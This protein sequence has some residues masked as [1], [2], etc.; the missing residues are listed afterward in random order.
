MMLLAFLL[1]FGGSLAL[2]LAMKRHSTQLMPARAYSPRLALSLRLL[3]SAM[4]I[5]GAVVCAFDQGPGVGLTT[6]FGLF[7][8]AIVAIA[9][10][11]PYL[12]QPKR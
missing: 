4:L 10:A 3:G 8:M 9:V 1:V 2:C 6:F 7:C 5:G 11:L 12:A